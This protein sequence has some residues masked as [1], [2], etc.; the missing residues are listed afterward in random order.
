MVEMP[1]NGRPRKRVT[2]RALATALACRAVL[3]V[4]DFAMDEEERRQ[5]QSFLGLTPNDTGNLK[6][7]RPVFAEFGR[8]F[9]ERFYQHLLAE[10]ATAALLQDPGQLEQLKIL[11][12]QYFAELLAGVF[13]EAYF[14]SRLR[15][16][17]THQRVGLEPVWYLGAYNQYIQ[18]T[19]PLF[20]RAFGNNLERVL[21]LLLSLVKVIF[22]DIGLAMRTYFSSATEQLRR[23]NEELKQALALYWEA[24]RRE[25]Q[26][27]KL[28]SHEVRGGLAAMITSLEDLSEVARG[29]LDPADVEQLEKVNKRC[30]SLSGLLREML[31]AAPSTGPTWVET[32]PIFESLV[33]RFSL[34]AEGRR[35]QLILPEHAPRVWAEPVQLREVFANLVSNAV[36]YL[37]GETGQVQIS[38]RPEG[39]SYAFCVADNGPGIAASVR[40]RLFEPFVRGPAPPGRPEGTGLGLY[41]VRTIIEQAGGR[42]WVESAP[43]Q[44]TRFWFTVP[45]QPAAP[46][47]GAAAKTSAIPSAGV[48]P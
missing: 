48:D 36:R 23:H 6:L 3:L 44:G 19:F 33:A 37:E 42:V 32:G 25:E 20:A 8:A 28:L 4:D 27:R 45:S 14:E 29:H 1:Y 11:Q 22:L 39:A 7:L 12:A 35:I 5:R 10:P 18:I 2:N 31:T 40:A 47:S 26:L 17:L 30:W 38:C 13:D 41:F 15:I 9:A 46:T 43:G 24:Q 21:P 16:G 34:Y